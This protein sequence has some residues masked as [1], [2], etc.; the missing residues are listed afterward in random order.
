MKTRACLI[1]LVFT[2]ASTNAH[3]QSLGEMFKRA[4]KDA[5]QEIERK[6]EN[7]AREASDKTVDAATAPVEEAISGTMPATGSQRDKKQKGDGAA[8]LRGVAMADDSSAA[9]DA[10]IT[11]LR[12]TPARATCA[13]TGTT[14]RVFGNTCNNREFPAPPILTA[15]QQVWETKPG[16]WGVWSPYLTD[17]L[18]LTGSCNN[19]DN[20]GLSAL[21]MQTGKTIWHIGSM[22][23]V[24]NRRGSTGNVAF[25]DMPSGEVLMV[26]PRDDG[27]PTDYY[28]I[29]VKTG[30]IVRSLKPAANV[31]LRGLGGIFTGVNQ[32]K[33]DGVSNL[34]SFNA[35]LDQVLWRNSGFRLAMEKE[36]PHYQPTFSPTVLENGVLFLTARSKD[37]PDPPTRQVHA[38]DMSTGQTRWRHTDQPA[39]ERGNKTW[40]SDDGIPMVAGGKVIVRVQGLLGA[41]GQGQKPSGDALRALD[42]RS[43]ATA[44]TTKAV[45]GASIIAHIAV[46]DILVANVERSDGR[47]LWGFRLSDGALAWR[48]PVNKETQLLASSG[49]AFYVSERIQVA[50]KEAGNYD[51]HL[52]GLDGE[53]GTLLWTTVLPGHNLDL[54]GGWGIVPDPRRSGSQGPAWR[55]GRDGAIYGITLTGAFKL[56]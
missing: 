18:M 46:G 50:G 12:S 10:A 9:R 26:Y 17:K 45:A 3:A 39:A 29:N 14:S 20:A 53:T 44:W 6:A 32:S 38:I 35:E 56:Q 2:L 27:G 30:R 11:R 8:S 31:P 15:P 22:C 42:S 16:W 54:D 33:A 1:A 28:V 41:V 21:D 5:K 4:V 24:G 23:A 7:K 13:D 25:F 51:F 43:G 19:D 52:Q 40:R 34:M 37:Q 55:I 36:D 49:G 48:R 47:E